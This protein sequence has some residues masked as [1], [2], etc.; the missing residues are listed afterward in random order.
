MLKGALLNDRFGIRPQDVEQAGGP[1]QALQGR[2]D[3][4]VLPVAVDIDEENI[5]PEPAPEGRDSIRDMLIP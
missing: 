2:G 1:A 5:V 4:G 3:L